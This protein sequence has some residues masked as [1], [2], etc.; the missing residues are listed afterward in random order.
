M[1]QEIIFRVFD[2]KNI[3]FLLGNT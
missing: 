2:A 3:M 1:V